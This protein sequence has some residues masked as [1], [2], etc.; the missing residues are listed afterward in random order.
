MKLITNSSL[1][2]DKE[3][4]LIMPLADLSRLRTTME[5]TQLYGIDTFGIARQITD[6]IDQHFQEQPVGVHRRTSAVPA[7]MLGPG[8][9]Y[10][11]RGDLVDELV[12]GPAGTALCEKTQPASPVL[13]TL[14]PV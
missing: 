8:G 3:A 11:N 14:P 12:G 7:L 10:I 4:M 1:L 5:R 9:E 2:G 13:T 6:T